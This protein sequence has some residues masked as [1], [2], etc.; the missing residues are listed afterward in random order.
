M[1]KVGRNMRTPRKLTHMLFVHHQEYLARAKIG[2]APYAT[3]VSAM[4]EKRT[5]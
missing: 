5:I 4:S 3:E 2:R 1:K